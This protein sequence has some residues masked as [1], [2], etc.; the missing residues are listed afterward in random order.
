V[1]HDKISQVIE[2]WKQGPKPVSKDKYHGWYNRLSSSFIKAFWD[3]E[4]ATLLKFVL[5]DP[6]TV[7]K[8]SI[9][10][11]IKKKAP[12]WEAIGN[13]V[14]AYVFCGEDAAGIV[15]EDYKNNFFNLSKMYKKD[16]NIIRDTGERIPNN[17]YKQA[18]LCA[19]AVLEQPL[20]M[21]YVKHEHAKFHEVIEF[22]IDGVPFKMEGDC[23]NVALG[24]ELD[25]KTSKD[26]NEKKWHSGVGKKV[27]FIKQYEYGTQRAIYQHG[28]YQKHAVRVLPMIGAVSKQT[29]PDTR[30]YEFKNQEALDALFEGVQETLPEILEV[31]T[32]EKEPHSC[33]VCD[34]CK[35]DKKLNG[36]QIVPNDE[37]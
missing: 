21:K 23:I 18:V 22:E 10:Q 35:R 36:V 34:Y 3:C 2:I 17:D 33:G 15:A 25:F 1:N 14:E 30:L 24:Y 20:F 32:G 19:E 9:E 31:L 11:R 4:Y 16:D 28:I 37:Y 5:D 29:I 27:G 8:L 7:E 26:I 6:V 12:E 13:F